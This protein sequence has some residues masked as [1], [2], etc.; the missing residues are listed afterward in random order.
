MNID[1]TLFYPLCGKNC[2]NFFLQR[3]FWLKEIPITHQKN[4]HHDSGY[5]FYMN[6]FNLASP[7]WKKID[8][9]RPLLKDLFCQFQKNS[10]LHLNHL[11]IYPDTKSCRKELILK[12][13]TCYQFS[14]HILGKNIQESCPSKGLNR[15]HIDE[16]QFLFDAVTEIFP[17]IFSSNLEHI[18]TYKRYW[19]TYSYQMDE[20]SGEM[21]GIFICEKDK[22]EDLKGDHI[23]RCS[24]GIYISYRYVCDGNKD[25]PGDVALDEVKCECNTTL[26]HTNQCK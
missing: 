10:E 14:W 18:F 19:N 23:F 16:F 1:E 12:N 22:S 21:E 9:S 6:I 4:V 17:P 11:Q 25:C 15:I 7:T 24:L 2:S 13:N 8:C 5:C 20:P 3:D 26:N